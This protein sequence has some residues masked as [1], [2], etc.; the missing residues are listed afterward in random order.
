MRRYTPVAPET[1]RYFFACVDRLALEVHLWQC[2]RFSSGSDK[3]PPVR[4]AGVR[5]K[6]KM[7]WFFV[8]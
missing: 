2:I 4:E 6:M 5:R 1:I 8:L 3:V 7:L